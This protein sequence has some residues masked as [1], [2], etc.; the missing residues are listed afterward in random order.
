MRGK[1]SPSLYP[2]LHLH[3]R[4]ASAHHGAEQLN[5]PPHALPAIAFHAERLLLPLLHLVQAQRQQRQQ[6]LQS[7]RAKGSEMR[8]A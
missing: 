6:R 4:A 1:H 2:T 8:M 7:M 5:M 3:D